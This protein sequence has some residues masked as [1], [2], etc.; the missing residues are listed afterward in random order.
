MAVANELLLERQLPATLKAAPVVSV[1]TAVASFQLSKAKKSADTHRKVKLLTERLMLFLEKRGLFN[2]A[3]VKLDDL[4]AFRAEWTGA[5]TTQHRDQEILKSF[6][7]YGVNADFIIKNPAIHMDAVKVDRPKTDPFSQE[8]EK[9]IFTALP[10]LP[11]GYGRTGGDIARQTKAFVLVLRYTGMSIGDVALL[12]KSSING[13]RIQTVRKKTGE[14]VHAS[15]PQFVVD[16]LNAAPHDSERYFFWS[17]NGLI[18][19]RTSK[20]G[21]RLRKLFKLAKVTATPHKYRHTFARDFLLSGGSMAELAELL[22]NSARVCERY[23]SKWDKQRQERL[24][25]NLDAM[26]EHDPI[27]AMLIAPAS[28]DIPAVGLTQESSE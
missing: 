18:H 5:S 7:K 22:G 3:D 6:F 16:E 25:R 10:N 11:D 23:Y 26:R 13:R 9:A 19:T 8:Q 21:D 14:L 2:M 4:T 1:A 17:G 20:W 28:C 12:E 27:T 24:E 15:V